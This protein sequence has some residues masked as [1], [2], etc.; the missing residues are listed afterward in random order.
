MAIVSDL[1]GNFPASL[2]TGVD[3][4]LS[5]VTRNNVGTPIGA[6]TPAFPGEIVLDTL[7]VQL[8]RATGTSNTSWTPVTGGV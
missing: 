7:S 8:Y 2:P 3:V 1:S 4:R 6:L 5:S